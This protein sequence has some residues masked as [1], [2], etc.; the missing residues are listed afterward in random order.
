MTPNSNSQPGLFGARALL[1]FFLTTAF[2]AASAQGQQYQVIHQFFPAPAQPYAG[3]IQGSDG[4]FYGTTQSGGAGNNGTVFK[5]NAS[6]TVTTLQSFAG[7]DG[8]QPYAGL[9]EGSDGNFY[10]TTVYG[11]A[12]DNGTVFKMDSSGVVTTLHSFAGSDGAFPIA[13]LI[14][15]SD[16]NF[17]GTT[18]RGGASNNGT[19]FKVDSSG[20]VTTLHSFAGQ[21]LDGAFPYS[22]LIQGSDGNFYG[23]TYQ[24]GTANN[25]TVF[26]MNFLGVVTTLH[27]F[28]GQPL[29]GAQPYAGLI[30]GSDGNFYGTTLFGGAA[31]NGTV[32]KMNSLGTTV[33]T[34]HSFA[35]QPLDG[36]F[37]YAGLVQ[38]PD[39]NFYGATVEGGTTGVGAVFKMDASGIVTAL[40]SFAGSDG[41]QPYA[42]L[43][44]V[45]DGNFYGTTLS[46]G[47]AD[48]GTVF[49]MDASA[50]V[51][52]L[53]SFAASD[54][55]NPSAALVQGT[56]RNF[57]GTTDWGGTTGNGTVF[58]MDASGV[59]TTLHFF[60]GSDGTRPYAGVIQGSDGN[61]YGV[62]V[63]GGANNNGTVFKMNA[64]GVLTTLY[65]F[66]GQ[67]LDGAIAQG[68]LIQGSDG[69][70]YGTTH[71][72]G[73]N[74]DGTVFKMDASGTLTTLH[75]FAG[76]EG[77]QPYAGLIQG[78]DGNFYGTTQFGGAD[79]NGT[80]FKMDAAGGVTTLHSFAALPSDDGA[81]PRCGLI[82]G[83]DG[84]FYG[85]AQLGGATGNGTVFKV[86]SSGAVTTL[87]A[88]TGSDG[89]Q[90]TGQLIQGNDRNFYGT[91]VIGGASNSGTVFKMNASGVVTTLHSFAGQPSDGSG[92]VAGLIQAS[93][94]SFYGTTYGGGTADSGTVFRI[95]ITPPPVQLLGVV[96]RKTHGS[97]GAYDINLP[98]TS[99]PGIECR[100]GGA[101]GDYTLVFTFVSALTNVGG[102]NVTS[103][104]GSVSSSNIDSN[105]AHNYIANL[106]GVTNAQS[107]TVSLTNVTDS[108]GNF[109]V[110]V[111][112]SM[113]VLLGDVNA[114]GRVDAADVSLVRQQ[115]L[116]S[117]TN[118][119]FRNDLNAS[120]RI[121]AADVSIAR[122]Q[123][124]TSLP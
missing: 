61:F 3:L 79:G 6:G 51:T 87:H 23:T 28:A 52:T 69:N 84:N 64:S 121:D 93:D 24:G 80:V 35:G 13:G 94:G 62:T 102:A 48:N 104:T 74:N 14:Q 108:A 97:A 122:Q 37:P 17:Y 106:T 110:A 5:M 90:P 33:T 86:D 70:F 27:S 105:D 71:F 45:S 120:G 101:N 60:A 29:D 25:G 55:M 16:G 43:I 18:F 77:A 2:L 89:S 59:V 10:G 72:G 56:D 12:A 58:K 19:V 99:A 34:L 65:S 7:S 123:T 111:S 26:K 66:T 9:V 22:G 76:S 32:F 109:S 68:R 63:T 81:R 116:Q 40:H 53:Y 39:G 115:T 54:G 96:S 78:N 11:G 118:S 95:N 75:S 46:G 31:D 107:I 20:A 4:N 98:L 21:P 91:T 41:A 73:T 117:I 119:N 38:G 100:S 85:T 50:A 82:Q 49:K 1:S 15:G 36:A 8:A 113:G 103:G 83:S 30:Q 67:P 42:G 112:A 92:P 88:F 57:Y 114:S 44:Q 47:T 124:L